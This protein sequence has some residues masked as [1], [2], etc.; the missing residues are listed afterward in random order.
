M[1]CLAFCPMDKMFKYFLTGDEIVLAD[2]HFP[3]SSVCRAGPREI[4]ADGLK[5]PELL[6]AVCTL[7]PLDSHVKNPVGLMAVM[8]SDKAK[9]VP[10]PSIWAEYK[11]IVD[12]AEGQ[13]TGFE[14]I[15]RF[16]FYERAKKAFAVV[17]TGETAIYANVI[18][19]KGVANC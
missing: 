7:L 6:K 13:K 4:R 17:H 9:G 10:T 16:A 15:E 1:V 12:A 5:M 3:S 8:E 14:E 11:T 19:K 18:L 2:A